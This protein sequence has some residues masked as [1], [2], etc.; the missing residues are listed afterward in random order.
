MQIA[1]DNA[2]QYRDLE[3][4]IVAAVVEDPSRIADAEIVE[5]AMMRD[6]QAR[7]AW[8]AVLDL[9]DE[10]EPID[11]VLLVDRLTERR[12]IASPQDFAQRLDSAAGAPANTAAY[13]RI[14]RDR[15]HE[16]MIRAATGALSHCTPE[17]VPEA[18]AR[19]AA[20]VHAR[21]DLQLTY[22]MPDALNAWEIEQQAERDGTALIVPTGIERLDSRIGGLRAGR[23]YIVA[24]R[25]GMGKTAF[26]LNIAR[27]AASGGFPCAF[28]SLEMLPEDLAARLISIESGA[29]ADVVAGRQ[30]PD[31]IFDEAG[32][33]AQ[34]KR[35]IRG[36]P[37]TVKLCPDAKTSR[38]MQAA[39]DEITKG[40]KVLIVDYLQKMQGSDFKAPRHEQI[41]EAVQALKNFALSHRVP[42]IVLCQLNRDLEKRDDKRPRLSDLRDSGW[43]EQEADCVLSVYRDAM[44]QDEGGPVDPNDCEIGVLK[45]RFGKVGICRARFYAYNQRFEG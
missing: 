2:Q 43:I 14:I 12:Q 11:P 19:L 20:L 28:V 17:Q 25:P 27:A 21:R 16:R 29:P 5:P 9:R 1:A 34:A 8:I 36:W 30:E 22:T 18:L 24:A 37:I 4:A 3:W 41:G 13:A 39:R 7:A 35:T 44:Y 15:H 10:G 31:Q 6:E 42:V 45:Q 32:R 33:I 38:V 40:A 26:A 23:L